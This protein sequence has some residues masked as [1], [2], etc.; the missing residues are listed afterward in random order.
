MSK[1]KLKQATPDV[2]FTSRDIIYEHFLSCLA[3]QLAASLRFLF[4]LL[5]YERQKYLRWLI[6]HIGILSVL[7][8]SY[9]VT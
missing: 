9:R 5:E 3:T 2:K 1:H 8:P 7:S 6:F 4:T